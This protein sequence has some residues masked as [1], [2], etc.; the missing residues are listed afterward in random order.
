M[1]K[2]ADVDQHLPQCGGKRRIR[3][4][5]FNVSPQKS[6]LR[7]HVDDLQGQFVRSN[8]RLLQ[9]S[10]SR[11]VSSWTGELFLLEDFYRKTLIFSPFSKESFLCQ[12]LRFRCIKIFFLRTSWNVENRLVHFTRSR[13][14]AHHQTRC[15]H[16]WIANRKRKMIIFWFLSNFIFCTIYEICSQINLILQSQSFMTLR[17][18][19]ALSVPTN[20]FRFFHKKRYQKKVL[21]TASVASPKSRYQNLTIGFRY[22]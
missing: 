19:K 3:R 17:F 18:S 16:F 21:V 6:I 7:L 10:G 2:I 9:F 11:R 5:T 13:R 4:K 12:K 14:F 1:C 20:H 15:Q 8:Q 22:F